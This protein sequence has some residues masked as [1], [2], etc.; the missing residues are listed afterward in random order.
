MQLVA[1]STMYYEI[2]RGAFDEQ[3]SGAKIRDTSNRCHVATRMYARRS[4]IGRDSIRKK[5]IGAAVA[6]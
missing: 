4:L 2:A 5:Y 6:P 3:N 1:Q